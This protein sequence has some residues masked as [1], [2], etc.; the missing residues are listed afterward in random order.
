MLGFSEKKFLYASKTLSV[1]ETREDDP[2]MNTA[3][4]VYLTV[5]EIELNNRAWQQALLQDLTRQPYAKQWQVLDIVHAACTADARNE[6][7]H[8]FLPEPLL[9]LIHGLPGSGKSQLMKWLRSYFEEVAMH[10]MSWRRAS[11]C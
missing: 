1:V 10:Q 5:S 6:N 4:S 2:P 3:A 8:R 7:Q 9:R 11:S